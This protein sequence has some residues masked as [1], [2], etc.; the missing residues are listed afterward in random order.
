MIT[1][2]R[3]PLF[4]L[5]PILLVG[6]AKGSWLSDVTGINIDLAK[7][8]GGAPQALT[9]AHQ[10]TQIVDP[11]V[12]HPQPVAVATPAQRESLQKQIDLAVQ[13]FRTKND[14]YQSYAAAS[15]FVTIFLHYARL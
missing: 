7:S 2:G 1:L 4:L 12:I 10:P 13:T 9:A 11:V 3:L 15:L 6:S 14:S 5:V 8:V